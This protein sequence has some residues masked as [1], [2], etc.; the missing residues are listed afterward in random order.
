MT[1]LVLINSHTV[2]KRRDLDTRLFAAMLGTAGS[3]CLMEMVSFLVDGHATAFCRAVSWIANTWTYMGNP[4]ISVLWLLYTDFHLHRKVKRLSTTYRL[5]LILLAACWIVTLGNLF[6]QYLFTI[7]AGNVYARRP[8]SYILFL[9]PLATVAAS[10][11][12]VYR[13]RR[14]H[15]VVIFFPVWVFLAPVLIG[16]FF[17][18]LFYGIS[19]TWCCTSLG[20]AALHMSMQNELAY[21]DSLTG[22]HNRNYM[23]LILNSWRGRSGIMIDMDYFKEINDRFGHSAGD[24]ALREAA[25]LLLQTVPEDSVCVR[26]AGDEFILLL[27]TR[28][29]PVIVGTEQKIRKAVEQFNKTSGRPYT[30]S[31]SMGH[32]SF[33]QPD[34]DSFLI[35]IDGAMYRE[36][37]L[38]HESGELKERRRSGAQA[39]EPADT[40][41]DEPAGEQGNEPAGA[42]V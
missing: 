27:T 26:F 23:D 1:L 8:A 24:E 21:R 33:N 38:R 2:R 36:K 4:L 29:E 7:N 14:T 9:M 28:Q 22:L 35:A 11:V 13:Y 30:L 15:R 25:G 40:Q 16:M 41:A 34:A 20:M 19:L 17:Q 5:Y 12:E 31:M 18:T 42:A 39:D 10:V 37:K 6:G 3:C 32:A